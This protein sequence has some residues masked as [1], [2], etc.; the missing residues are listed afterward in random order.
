MDEFTY[1]E[2]HTRTRNGRTVDASLSRVL[3]NEIITCT[4]TH[5]KF[6]AILNVYSAEIMHTM[7]VIYAFN[8][9]KW[10][11]SDMAWRHSSYGPRQYITYR[12]SMSTA[13]HKPACSY[14]NGDDSW[15]THVPD[16]LMHDIRMYH[17][18]KLIASELDI[19]TDT[20]IWKC[21][22]GLPFRY[23]CHTNYPMTRVH[24][25]E[26]LMRDIRM[27]TLHKIMASSLDIP[28]DTLSTVGSFL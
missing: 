7:T 16:N 2:N 24:V 10:Y 11:K 6:C 13:C 15:V 22:F 26:N 5:A 18:R 23:K 21:E 12:F 17:T 20:D 8:T 14:R 28:T 3:G 9:G 27:Y 19:P 1:A 25:H 4:F